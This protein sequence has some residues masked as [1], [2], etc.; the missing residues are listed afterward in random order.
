MSLTIAATEYQLE[1]GLLMYLTVATTEFQQEQALLMYAYVCVTTG[2]SCA[3][4]QQR[5]SD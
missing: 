1:K 2:V 5:F 4:R 3:G